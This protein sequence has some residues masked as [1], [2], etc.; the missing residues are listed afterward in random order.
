MKITTLVPPGNVYSQATIA[1]AKKFGINLINCYTE[2][3]IEEGIRILGDEQV[4]AFHDRELVV[5][6][7]NW[8]RNLLEKN[9]DTNYCFVKEL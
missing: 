2:S 4:V 7:V 8:L 1:A 9:R 3:K 6:G 5:N